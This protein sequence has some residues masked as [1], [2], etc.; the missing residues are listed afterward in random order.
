MK[1]EIHAHTD[2]YSSCSRIVPAELVAMAEAAG[3]EALFV[4]DHGKVWSP[5]DL[6]ELREHC[7]HLRIFPGIEIA[8]PEGQDLLVLGADNPIYESLHTP[9]EVLAQACA[10]D[11][12]TVLAHP[13]R[14]DSVLPEYCSL[15]DASEVLTCNHPLPGQAAQASA[16][17][18]EHNMAPVYASDAHGLNFMNRFWLETEAAFETPQE[19]RRLILAG[20]YENQRR[21]SDA[22]LPPPNK[23]ATMTGLAE[24]DLV[25]LYA[26][27]TTP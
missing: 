8:L 15:L 13:F 24:E 4:T 9:S 12:L 2:R 14:W 26:Q 23:V 18:R 17:A 16:Y 25:A 21:S 1:V 19:F 20:R 27:P 22:P 11:Y 6:A 10:D 7:N 5:H 3:Y